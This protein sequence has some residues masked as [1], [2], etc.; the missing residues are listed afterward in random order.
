ML[1]WCEHENCTYF[2][3]QLFPMQQDALGAA[4]VRASRASSRLKL[5]IFYMC[6][7]MIQYKHTNQQIYDAKIL[8]PHRIGRLSKTIY[9]RFPQHTFLSSRFCFSKSLLFI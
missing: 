3:I 2:K 6:V 1:T 7:L 8:I 4:F 9:I 5:E